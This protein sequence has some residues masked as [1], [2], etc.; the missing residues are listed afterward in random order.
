[1][2]E[3]LLVTITLIVVVNVIKPGRTPPL[4]NPLVIERVGQY[5]ITLAPQLNL[6]QSLIESIAKGLG[7]GRELNSNSSTICME[8]RD[9]EVTAHGKEFYLLAITQRNGMLYFQATSSLADERKTRMEELLAFAEKT[10]HAFPRAG[11]PDAHLSE[12]I[13][14]AAQKVALQYKASISIL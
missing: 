12:R 10:L 8:V 9:A 14:L 4:K 3:F 11:N 7:N 1:M 13:I 6:A 2:I 5:H